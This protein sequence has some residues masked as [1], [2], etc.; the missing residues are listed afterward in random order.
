M[1]CVKFCVNSLIYLWDAIL[2]TCAHNHRQRHHK[3]GVTEVRWRPGQ[4][5]SL[6]PPYSNLRP[7]GSKC[8]VL[9]KVLVHDVVGTFRCLPAIRRPGNCA[10]FAPL[11]TPLVRKLSQLTKH[12]V[13]LHW[14]KIPFSPRRLKPLSRSVSRIV[15]FRFC[16]KGVHSSKLAPER[17]QQTGNLRP[18]SPPSTNSIATATEKTKAKSLSLG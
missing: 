12:C 6:A 1:R 8:T 15:E 5:T 4:E 11:V 10:P 17:E 3:V 9:K 13:K 2:S 14:H 16:S 7:L 18:A